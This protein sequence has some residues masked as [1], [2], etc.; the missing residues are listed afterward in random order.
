MITS[1]VFELWDWNATGNK[2]LA[3]ESMDIAQIEEDNTWKQFT[4]LTFYTATCVNSKYADAVKSG[5]VDG[6]KFGGQLLVKIDRIQT[7]NPRPIGSHKILFN[8]STSDE[9]DLKSKLFSEMK[10]EM[11]LQNRELTY[12]EE[13]AP[14]GKKRL[15]I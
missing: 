7:K 11:V 4:W 2:L 12:Y 6:N 9:N 14:I 3:T 10:K 1:V 5:F 15:G 8:K 13:Q